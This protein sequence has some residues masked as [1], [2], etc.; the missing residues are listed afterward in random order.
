MQ[1]LH[2]YSCRKKAKH[3]LKFSMIMNSYEL[4]NLPAFLLSSITSGLMFIFYILQNC[5]PLFLCSVKQRKLQN[6]CFFLIPRTLLVK[7]SV[8]LNILMR[9]NLQ[10]QNSHFLKMGEKKTD[11]KKKLSIWRRVAQGIYY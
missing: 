1:Q 11:Q 4:E 8:F 10:A 9:A 2:I 6:Q 7:L 3:Y 5:T